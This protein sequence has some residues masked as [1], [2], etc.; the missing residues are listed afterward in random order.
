MHLRS[1]GDD[2]LLVPPP[3]DSLVKCVD[4]ALTAKETCPIC[5]C[6][7]EDD[8]GTSKEQK[9][10]TMADSQDS[11][12]E[13]SKHKTVSADQD[14][15]KTS[16]STIK[17]RRCADDDDDA[18][19]VSSKKA[20]QGASSDASAHDDICQLNK[21]GCS[22]SIFFH[23]WVVCAGVYIA[24]T[25]NAYRTGLPPRCSA[26]CAAPSTGSLQVF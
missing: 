26:R 12:K 20:K 21:C 8:D 22:V 6:P 3:L 9:A 2:K 23:M 13:E 15:C 18:G 10:T 17:R 16:S 25:S 14:K 5:F 24:F 11:N 7:L 4:A 19:V 1:A